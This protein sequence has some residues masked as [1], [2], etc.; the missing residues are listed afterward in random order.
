MNDHHCCFKSALAEPSWAE[1]NQ[2]FAH[3]G[4]Q[5]WLD[6]A[7]LS[8]AL[9]LASFPAPLTRGPGNHC[10]RVGGFNSKFVSKTLCN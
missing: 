9:Q 6:S 1:S 8:R 4:A 3:E 10:L 5:L 7:Q 2:R